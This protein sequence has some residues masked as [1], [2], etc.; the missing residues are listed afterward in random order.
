[1]VKK[2]L[3]VTDFYN[4]HKSGIITYIDNIINIIKKK[5][6]K[7]TILTTLHEYNLKE[8]EIINNVEIIRCKP[9]I[10]I[11]R[12]FYSFELVLKF[13][14]IRKNFNLINIHYPLVEI[15][16]II[17][18]TNK[19]KTIINYHCLPHFPFYAKLVTFYFYIF[20]LVSFLRSKSIIT[21][22]F[23]YQKN[24][25]LHKFFSNRTYEI[26]P[27][28]SIPKFDAKLKKK[29]SKIKIGYL[30]RLSN[31]KGLEYLISA[32]NKLEENNINH[33]LIIAGN[34]KD[35]RFKKYIQKLKN[36]SNKNVHFIGKIDEKEKKEFYQNLDIF[37]LPSVNSLEAFGIVQLEAMS[38]GIPVIASNIYGVRSIIKNTNN[39]YLFKNK[40]SD[41]LFEKI[42]ICKNNLQ[43]PKFVIHNVIKYYNKEKFE[44]KILKLFS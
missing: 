44:K 38:F 11:S 28:I 19:I 20:G 2:V 1:M 18:F 12:G 3:I 15:F 39:G 34:N 5:N 24:I 25:P 21:L 32:S 10:K 14:K 13:I 22:S 26:P 37:I 40:N 4:P 29:N 36:I 16:P 9:T 41:D 8:N 33:D 17:F 43:L 31:E 27:Y 7:I 30:G 42:L 23:D 6:Y 35:F